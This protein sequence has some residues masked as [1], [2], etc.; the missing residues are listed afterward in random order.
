VRAADIADPSSL[1]TEETVR[2]S[3]PVRVEYEQAVVIGD[4]GSCL[5]SVRGKNW[6]EGP[7][8]AP[9]ERDDPVHPQRVLYLYRANSVYNRRFVQR[10]ELKR[11]LGREHRPLV[12]KANRKTQRD[13]IAELSEAQVRAIRRRFRIGPKEFWRAVRG[14]AFLELPAREQQRELEFHEPD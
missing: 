9:L 8:I 13:F 4:I 2:K 3:P 7:W 5:S 11:L 6:G 14:R 1:C 12:T 10:Q